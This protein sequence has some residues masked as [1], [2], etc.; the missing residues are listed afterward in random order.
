M[1]QRHPNKHIQAAIEFAIENGWRLETH[2]AHWGLLLCPGRRR[3]ACSF[4][5]H[6]TPRTPEAHAKDI[7]RTV[8]RCECERPEPDD[9]NRGTNG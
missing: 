8:R 9:G 4:G 1:A 2:R 5:V 7:V 6:S 3:G